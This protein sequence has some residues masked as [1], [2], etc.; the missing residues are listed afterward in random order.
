MSEESLSKAHQEPHE[1]QLP[2]STSL[3]D[4]ATAKTNTQPTRDDAASTLV[5][6]Q[7]QQHNTINTP[8]QQQ[9]DTVAPPQDQAA[10]QGEA[11]SDKT[12]TQPSE[13]TP[14][15][16][17]A[18]HGVLGAP[19]SP[20]SVKTPTP[21]NDS[22]DSDSD[23]PLAQ[24]VSRAK[25]KQRAV[26]TSSD[27]DASGG[28]GLGIDGDFPKA[29][30]MPSYEQYFPRGINNPAVFEEGANA[31]MQDSMPA[32][33]S[34]RQP[35]REVVEEPQEEREW[36]MTQADMLERIALQAH[37]Y[38]SI[39]HRAQQLRKTASNPSLF[40]EAQDDLEDL[41][42]TYESLST[43]NSSILQDR[44]KAIPPTSGEQQQQQQ[45]QLQTQSR[46]QQQRQQEQQQQQQQLQQ[47]AAESSNRKKRRDQEREAAKQAKQAEVNRRAAQAAQRRGKARKQHLRGA[48][49]RPVEEIDKALWQG[50]KSDM[51]KKVQERYDA[52]DE[53]GGRTYHLLSVAAGLLAAEATK[54]NLDVVENARNALMGFANTQAEYGIFSL[55]LD[56]LVREGAMATRLDPDNLT[57]Q[58]HGKIRAECACLMLVEKC[59]S[60]FP[61]TFIFHGQTGQVV[62]QPED[63]LQRGASARD[64]ERKRK[65]QRGEPVS[66]SSDDDDDEPSTK[67]P[68]SDPS[69]SQEVEQ[70]TQ[71]AESAHEEQQDEPEEAEEQQ[72]GELTEEQRDKRRKAAKRALWRAKQKRLAAERKEREKEAAREAKT[73]SELKAARE[74]DREAKARAQRMQASGVVAGQPE[75][76]I[77]KKAADDN[78][79]EDAAAADLEAEHASTPSPPLPSA[80][81]MAPTTPPRAP[82]TEP[83][84][85]RSN[86]P[87][88]VK[89]VDPANVFLVSPKAGRE[90]A[91]SEPS[92]PL[93][94][95]RSSL[96]P[97][98][99]NIT[100]M[101]AAYEDDF[102]HRRMSA[103]QISAALQQRVAER[104]AERAARPPTSRQG[105]L[106]RVLS[107]S[108]TLGGL[109]VDVDSLTLV[110][111]ML[112]TSR[113]VHKLT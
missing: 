53:R 52:G 81:A 83:D 105:S 95:G 51:A 107:D 65:A 15:Q 2:T 109:E 84:D 77:T 106:R 64:V 42:G 100:G 76:D 85:E 48:S 5:T 111:D 1:T 41:R 44:A 62:A 56:N 55:E 4:A 28:V 113:V 78:K 72:H 69:S 10:G 63:Y 96:D 67:K 60:P 11:S 43:L 16:T 30:D 21:N 23:E 47:H 59:E 49:S 14:R 37:E 71:S 8:Q 32:P 9:D 108:G 13:T 26:D 86:F 91:S 87:T 22:S 54:E 57:R 3:D 104:E 31:V 7:E 97:D 112:S 92:T 25:E 79:S 17:D 74:R 27:E 99:P 33:I 19:F 110:S 58:Q 35:V 73:A 80:S 20:S 36:V 68:T 88:S 24:R 102:K 66:S 12:P 45:P 40:A 34:G 94:S 61:D 38:A 101:A 46:L 98:S 90:G 103:D 93:F 89:H 75:P 50:I 29:S 70:A 82:P 39:D 18:P 6:T